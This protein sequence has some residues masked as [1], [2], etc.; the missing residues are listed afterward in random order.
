LWNF[1]SRDAKPLGPVRHETDIEHVEFSPSDAYVVTA[2]SSPLYT[3]ETAQVWEIATLQPVGPA[4]LHA[5]GVQHATFSPDERMVLTC[6]EDYTAIIW[7]FHT[8]RMLTPPLQ[9]AEQVKRGAFDPTGRWVVTSDG[10][11]QIQVWSTTGGEPL[12]SPLK[13]PANII[14]PRFFPDSRSVWLKMPGLKTGIWN[15]PFDSR[16]PQDLVKIAQLLSAQTYHPSG[17]FLPQDEQ[18]LQMLWT[19]LHAQF[20]EDFA[21]RERTAH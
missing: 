21:Y 15:L 7:D 16:Q 13:I 1:L 6:S 10:A 3:S 12:T 18:N 17:T 8:G 19:E 4:L 20:P 11:G 5:D 9:H 2:R 14:H